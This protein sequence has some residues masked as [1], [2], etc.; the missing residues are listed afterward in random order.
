MLP[1][2]ADYFYPD[3]QSTRLLWYHDHAHGITRINAYAGI[4][5]GY[6][7]LDLAQETALA[8][9]V[10]SIFS[11]I[12]LVF[13]D[14]IFVDPATIG[15]RRPNLGHSGTDRCPDPWKPLVCPCLRSHQVAAPGRRQLYYAT[16]PFMHSGV[17]RRHHA[18]NGLVYPLL[19]VEPK[20]Y[21][22]FFLNAT[23]ARFLNIN[24]LQVAPSAEGTIRAAEIATDPTT[25]VP[26]E[27]YSSGPT[28]IQIG[29]E[30]GY[31][32]QEVVYSNNNFFNPITLTGN[33]LLGNA[34]RA[35]CI[36]DFS[37]FA[38]GTE[39]IMYN[40]APGPFPGGDPAN[41]YFLGNPN[42]LVQPLPGTG[43][44]TRQILR[45]KVQGTG[46]WAAEPTPSLPI[47]SAAGVGPDPALLG[48]CRTRFR[49][50]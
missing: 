2:Q 39:F 23:N 20:A 12:P 18:L 1:G 24:L 48:G 43:P 31:L 35:D 26:D 37:G 32:A 8:G 4:A 45:I 36:I 10:P 22:F 5:T 13:Q 30:G 6:L 40:D 34:E 28:I 7:L 49:T 3:D 15:G 17:L 42:N 47:L 27:R 16:R 38:D 41:D 44:D 33:L 25:L 21:R 46:K 14:K 9:K 50:S 29:T 19:T 11:T